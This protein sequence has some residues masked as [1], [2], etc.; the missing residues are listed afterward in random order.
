[1]KNLL[2]FALSVSLAWFLTSCGN[3]SST[4]TQASVGDEPAGE[5]TDMASAEP[6][7]K[8]ICLWNPAGLR[9]NAGQGKDNKYLASIQFGEEVILTGESEEVEEGSRTRNYIEMT[10]ADGKTGW[11]YDYLFAVGASRAVALQPIDIFKRP[12]LTTISGKQLAEGSLFAVSDTDKEGWYEVSGPEKK[13]SGWIQGNNSSY[14]S[15]EIDVAV[16]IKLYQAKAE[17]SPVKR[18]AMLKTLTESSTFSGSQLISLVNAE[19]EKADAGK[20]LRADQLMITGDVLNVRSE[21][22]S[23]ADNVVFQLQSGDVAEILQRG[24]S[25]VQI[26]EM[27]DYWYQVEKDGQ[28]GWIYGAFTTKAQK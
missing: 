28:V 24:A 22:N 12:D 21:P 20:N 1:M 3:E 16:A 18:E 17:K 13:V 6:S 8:A 15:D 14:S 19:L 2:K 7:N 23:E 11:S 10:L 5:M 25:R 4:T 26:R 9:E 27:N